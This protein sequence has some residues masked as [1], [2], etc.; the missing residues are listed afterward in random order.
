MKRRFLITAGRQRFCRITVFVCILLSACA[1]GLQESTGPNGSNVQGVHALGY[2]GQGISVGLISQ[3]HARITHEAF[4]GHASCY[5]ATDPANT[6]CLPSNHDT[7]VGGIICSR[8]GTAYPDDKGTAPDSELY[9]VKIAS[10]TSISSA[11][12][13]DGLDYLTDPTRECKVVVTGVH[14]VGPDLTPDGDSLWSLIY[15]YYAYEHNIIFATAAGNYETS[16]TVFGDTYNSITTGGLI[17][18]ATDLYDKVGSG[19]NPGLTVDNRKKPDISAPSQG[20]WVP[21]NGD[22]SWREEGTTAGQ[23]SWSAP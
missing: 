11:W 16:I 14:L 4:A 22:T 6:T 23:T 9:S 18:T 10:D 3:D 13:V 15:D 20:Q 12:I 7:S 19:S 8:G 2:T 1:F 17:G 5:N 21:I